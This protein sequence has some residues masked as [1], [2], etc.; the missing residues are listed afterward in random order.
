MLMVSVIV[1]V[2]SKSAVASRLILCMVFPLMLVKVLLG[3]R[4]GLPSCYFYICHKAWCMVF[5]N[6][7][8]CNGG[9]VRTKLHPHRLARTAPPLFYL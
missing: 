4:C 2:S 1:A 6:F 9:A 3:S 5:E 7:F 8:S